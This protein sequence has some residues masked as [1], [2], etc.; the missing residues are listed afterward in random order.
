V[1]GDSQNLLIVIC[2]IVAYLFQ[3]AFGVI[4]PAMIPATQDETA[5][6]RLLRNGV[7]AM[8]ADVVKGAEPLILA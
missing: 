1:P 6:L 3:A 8:A 2:F 5:A 7:C 4:R